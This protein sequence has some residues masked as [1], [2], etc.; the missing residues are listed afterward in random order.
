MLQVATG[1]R[2]LAQRAERRLQECRESGGFP[3]G[4]VSVTQVDASVVE[5]D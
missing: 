5:K 3:A 1:Y 4:D 2:R